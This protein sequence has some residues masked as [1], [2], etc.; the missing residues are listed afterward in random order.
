M[1][2]FA[3]LQ[4]LTRE[5][6]WKRICTDGKFNLRLILLGILGA[7][8]LLTGNLVGQS[9]AVPKT[10]P[11][12]ENNS[13]PVVA[14]SY[15]QALESKLANLLSQV[16]G[17]GPVEVSVTLDTGPSQEYAQDVTRE[18]RVILEKD[19][20]GGLRTTTETKE[21]DQIILGKDNGVD[22]PIIVRETKP[23]IKGVLVIAAGAQDS[24]V[25]A[26]LTWA[27]E[28]GLGIPAYKISVLPQKL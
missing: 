28:A 2:I 11:L 22:R 7:L 13:Q 12:T 23:E 20:N 15:E 1:N 25:K 26:N 14:P 9:P 3:S 5:K 21:T 27:V 17:A 8:L 4:A 19:N 16:K 24:T 6:W 10:A 18:N